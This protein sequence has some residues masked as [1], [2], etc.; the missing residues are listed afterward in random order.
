MT[1]KHLGPVVTGLA[2]LALAG[3]VAAGPADAATA[4]ARRAGTSDT[5]HA[6]HSHVLDVTAVD[7][8][9]RVPTHTIRP[10]L[11]MIR[12]HN[13]GTQPHQADIARLHDGISVDQF[14]TA[15][16]Q[17]SGPALGMVDFRGGVNT[18]APGATA[19]AYSELSSGNY[20]LL[21]FAEGA[22]RVPHVAKG[23]VASFKVEGGADH[24]RTPATKGT[25]GLRSYGFDL[26][27]GFGH[28]T[29]EVTNTGDETHEMSLLRV[30]AGKTAHDV[31]TYLEAATPPPGPPPFT[32][33][34]GIGALA[35]G[36]SGFVKVH[37]QAGDY[38]ATCFVPDDQPPHLPHF[39]KGMFQPFTVT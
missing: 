11:D 15:L 25:V 17:G 14:V 39:M 16:S 32:A 31:L 35:P 5:A 7:F 19:V 9:Y 26:P 30:A 1:P 33:A 22:D 10:G 2:A 4:P 27:D 38:V 36:A 34:G 20:V 29:Y 28:G 12:L 18:I 23:M 13:A 8:S 21:C 37:L 24:S 6:T 3:A